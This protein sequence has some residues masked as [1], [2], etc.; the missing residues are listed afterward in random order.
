MTITDAVGNGTGATATAAVDNGV[1]TAITVT[2]RG[3]GYVTGGG[4][5]KFADPLPGL[6]DPAVRQLPDGSQR[7]YI[8]LGVPEE[9]IYN[10]PD[11]KPIKA[12]EYEIGLVQYR[13]KFSTDLPAHA[14]ARLRAARDAGQRRRQPA[15]PARRTSCSTAPRSTS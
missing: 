13:T 7:K 10:D 1:V 4:I 9:K 11:G 8:P 15:L 6:C 12:D 14:G 3:T 2:A 5:K